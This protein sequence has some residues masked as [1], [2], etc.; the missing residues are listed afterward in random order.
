MVHLKFF[1]I[2]HLK[3][4]K[5]RPD[6]LA[7]SYLT[8]THSSL[9]GLRPQSSFQS[10]YASTF[11][12]LDYKT[13]LPDRIYG[14]SSY[15]GYDRTP[16]FSS[17][18][19]MTTMGNYGPAPIRYEELSS[20][21]GLGY[22]VLPTQTNPL[23]S[24]R[25]KEESPP[26]SKDPPFSKDYISSSSSGRTTSDIPPP[27]TV[28]A[29]TTSYTHHN[30]LNLPPVV[31]AQS[32]N[33]GNQPLPDVLNQEDKKRNIYTCIYY[34][35]KNHVEIL[36]DLIRFIRNVRFWNFLFEHIR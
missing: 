7:P 21:A 36:P 27:L 1:Q 23:L 2:V 20:N 4:T 28:P 19:T 8:S 26:L 14:D 13:T 34:P 29:T 35:V 32:T 30:V 12:G 17:E 9:Y 5:P 18:P 33:E 24:T 3:S 6:P 25:V 16:P 31:T 15:H 11:G 22:K 10:S